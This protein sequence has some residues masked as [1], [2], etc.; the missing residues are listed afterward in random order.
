M[1][2]LEVEQEVLSFGFA[3]DS[4]VFG[5]PNGFLCGTLLIVLL[6]RRLVVHIKL[7]ND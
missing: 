4:T 7:I 5:A 1:V 3:A 2:E 6:L